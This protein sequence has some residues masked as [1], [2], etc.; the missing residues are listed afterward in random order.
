MVEFKNQLMAFK[1]GYIIDAVNTNIR[2]QN[3]FIKYVPASKRLFHF[4][5]KVIDVYDVSMDET[6]KPE[7]LTLNC[8]DCM[9]FD[10]KGLKKAGEVGDI[11]GIMNL[12]NANHL[13]FFDK[14]HSNKPA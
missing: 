10:R 4:L 9:Q 13:L 14:P 7:K 12:G 3:Y 8:I 6:I 5:D 2:Q 1:N 11:L